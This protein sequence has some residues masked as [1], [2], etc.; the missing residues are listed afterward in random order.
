MEGAEER[1]SAEAPSAQHLLTSSKGLRKDQR[2]EGHDYR[3]QA[4]PWDAYILCQRGSVQGPAPLLIY[5]LLV[6]TSGVIRWPMRVTDSIPDSWLHLGAA[7]ATVGI[8]GV[9]A[10]S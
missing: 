10:R 5:F 6:C 8:W 2:W 7:L 1:R 4:T 9:N 3:S